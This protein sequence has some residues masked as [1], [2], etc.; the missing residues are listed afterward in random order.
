M[1]KMDVYK[2]VLQR[3]SIR[4]FQ[5]KEIPSESMDKLTDALIWAPSAGNLQ[6]RKFYFI[7]DMEIKKKIAGAA[8]NQGFIADAPL[9]VIGCTDSAISRRYGERGVHLYSIQD[10][11]ASLMCMMLVAFEEGLGTVWV[12][13]FM[14][15]DV[16]RVLS[17]P[18][19]LRAVAIVPVGYPSKI[20]P[21]PPRVS[22]EEAVEF[23]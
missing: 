10:V 11:S 6:S 2:A 13:A 22:K 5:K 7:R 3:R 18:S 4:H 8:L 1:G 15:E 17:L 9:V 20:P 23:I 16:G 21:P 12:G 14:E 19:N